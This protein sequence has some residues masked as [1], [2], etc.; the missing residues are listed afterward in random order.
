LISVLHN[1]R[2]FRNRTGKQN[3]DRE[4]MSRE[5]EDEDEDEDEKA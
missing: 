2:Q 3:G 4:S 5:I 1:N